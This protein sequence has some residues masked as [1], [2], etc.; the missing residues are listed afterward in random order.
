MP[1][2]I[3]NWSDKCTR[4]LRISVAL[5]QLGEHRYDFTQL[6]CDGCFNKKLQALATEMMEEIGEDEEYPPLNEI[7]RNTKATIIQ[8]KNLAKSE[9][10]SAQQV[11]AKKYGLNS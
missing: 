4:W 2:N 7:S 11:V 5:T 8:G 6:W 10:R 9:I 3:S 1:Q